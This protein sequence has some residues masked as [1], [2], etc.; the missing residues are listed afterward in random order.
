M[1]H[2]WIFA[3]L[4]SGSD[5]V[6][7]PLELLAVVGFIA[8]WSFVMA[9]AARRMLELRTGLLRLFLSGLVGVAAAAFAVGQQ[10][11]G[12]EWPFIVLWVGVGVLAAM[13]LLIL[14]EVVVSVGARPRPLQWYRAYRH[15][16]QRTRRYAQLS[17]IAVRHGLGAYFFGRR[18][19]TT[20]ARGELARR[21]RLALEEGGVAFVKCG[22]ILS[23]RYDLLPPEFIDELS[24]L[25]SQVPPV[26]WAELE[27]LLAEELGA[28]VGEVFDSFDRVP[29]AAAS[30]G[31]VHRAQLRTGEQVVVKLQRPGIRPIVEGDLDITIRMARMLHRRAEWARSIGICDLADGFAEALREELDFT[32]EA[33]NMAVV[34]AARSYDRVTTAGTYPRLCTSRVLVMDYLDGLPLDQAAPI[35]DEHGLD[36][37]ALARTLLHTLLTQIMLDGVFLADPHPGN[38]LLLRDGRLGLLDFGSVGRLDANVRVVLQRLLLAVDSADPTALSDALLDIVDRPE[39]VNET[40][41][42]RAIGRFMAR[43]LGPGLDLDVA[44]FTD[45]FRLI[46]RH[47]IG[48]PPELA[49]V[50]RAL[51]T[52]EG[53]LAKL[54]PGFRIVDEARAFAFTHLHQAAQPGN[55]RATA[56]A[57]LVKLLPLIRRIPR[58]LDRLTSALEHGRISIGTRP[59]ADDRDRRHLTRLVHQTLFTLLATATGITAAMLLGTAGGPEVTQEV[60]LYQLIGYSLLIVSAALALRVLSS[61]LRPS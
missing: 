35:I 37:T 38:L 33:R 12:Q 9:I 4:P 34:T 59:F 22:Q 2:C 53:T 23:T 55:L 36:R 46:S 58:R 17:R 52:V 29:L 7:S 11:E 26:E 57:E 45:L 27:S 21:L 31:Q 42:E 61:I 1:R 48:I 51:A 18:G 50:F 41:L 10:M 6:V 56:M 16:R 60:S 25:Q 28:P 44:M 39:D 19:H 54:A 32:V 8:F 3:K 24:R 15:W 14:G 13:G 49:A 47:G 20:R 5:L 40:V 30:I 43:H